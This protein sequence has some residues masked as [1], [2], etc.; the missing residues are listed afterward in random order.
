MR[1]RKLFKFENAHIVR[2][3]TSD[4]CSRSIHG[5]SYEVELI[6]QADRLDNGQ[7]VY[8]FGL[9]KSHIKDIIDSFDHAI[10]FWNQDNEEYIKACKDFSA[11]W[12]S[13]PVSP[14]AEQFS[15]VIFCWADAILK[16]TITQNGEQDVSVY[17]VIVHETATG[18][19]QC[20]YEDVVNAQMGVLDLAAFEF[21]EQ[22]KAEWTD[23]TMFDKLIAGEKFVNPMPQL[24]VEPQVKS[25]IEPQVK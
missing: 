11:R 8:D 5:H 9:L 12:V 10:T 14:S 7:M 19:A 13:L 25:Q 2:N 6:L 20:F 17:S 18:Y 21:S 22:V 3:C 16:N 24:Q 4:R 15:R 23:S 1:I